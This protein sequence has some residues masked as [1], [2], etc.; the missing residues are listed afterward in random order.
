MKHVMLDLETM[1]NGSRAAI[2]AIGACEF[3]PVGVGVLI[4]SSHWFYQQIT[5]QSSVDAGL[6]I[7]AN[8]VLWWLQQSDAARKS[9]FEGDKL[10]PL[11]DALHS[12]SQWMA[13]FGKD[14]AVWGN[15]STFDNVIIRSA[16]KAV[17][18]PVPWGFRG[19]KCYR[20]VINLLPEPRRPAFERSGIAHNALDDAINQALYLQKVYK[21]LR[22]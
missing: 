22:L 19:D 20:T 15:A 17:K 14:A 8:T 10:W 3:D 21:E 7:D 18:L 16:Y 13:P 1:G 4:D 9:T 5:L 11:G 12:F 6:D 2:V